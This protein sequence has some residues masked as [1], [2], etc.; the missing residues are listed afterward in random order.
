MGVWTLALDCIAL[1]CAK[2]ARVM[3]PLLYLT[4]LV[5]HLAREV[6]K[7]ILYAGGSV[8]WFFTF[9]FLSFLFTVCRGERVKNGE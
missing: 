9:F 3:Y 5:H 4:V 7:G 2:G 8:F 6:E 1:R